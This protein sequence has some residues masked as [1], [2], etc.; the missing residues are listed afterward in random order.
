MNEIGVDMS[1]EFPKPLTDEAVRASDVVIT[2]GCGDVCPV[3]PGKRYE[4]WVLADPAGQDLDTVRRI[5]D[6]LDARV[7][8]L[9]AE[10]V[11]PRPRRSERYSCPRHR[12]RR[13]VRGTARA[14]SRNRPLE[15]P[16]ATLL[17]GHVP[18]EKRLEDLAMRADQRGVGK[19]GEQREQIVERHVRLQLPSDLDDEV[20]TLGERDD[21]LEAARERARDDVCELTTRERPDEL[22]GDG[23][24]GGVQP[25]QPVD[26]R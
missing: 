18:A 26:A 13:A 12:Q 20:S 4:D 1:E 3:Y 2:M 8:A 5:R 25:T 6:E 24:S 7:R 19:V 16:R 22:S 17:A 23:T 21:R 15:H 9:V 11:L 14:R 10:R